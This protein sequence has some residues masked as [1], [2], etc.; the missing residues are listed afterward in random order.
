M[1]ELLFYHCLYCAEGSGVLFFDFYRVLRE[2]QTANGN[3]HLFWMFEN[4][5]SMPTA[6]RDVICRFLKV[7]TC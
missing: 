2:L 1:T 7:T 3:T 6:F 4:V 5:T